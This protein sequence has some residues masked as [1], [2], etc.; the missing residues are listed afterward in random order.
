MSNI[1]E[2]RNLNKEYKNFSL[3][4]IDLSIPSGYIMGYVGQNGA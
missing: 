2:I 4:D 3:K 1:L